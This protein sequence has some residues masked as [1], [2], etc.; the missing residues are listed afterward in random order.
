[1]PSAVSWKDFQ[2]RTGFQRYIHLLRMGCLAFFAVTLGSIPLN[3]AIT[4]YQVPHPKAI[5]VLGGDADRESFTAHFV[6]HHPDLPIWFSSG[7]SEVDVLDLFEQ[8]IEA[9]V[10]QPLYF[11][12]QAVDTVTNFTTLVNE[13][14]RQKIR[15][16]FLITSD[17][18]MNR[19]KIIASIVLG[20]RKIV[21]TPVSVPSV[22]AAEPQPKI[23]RDFFRSLFW[24]YTGW[25][26]ENI[27]QNIHQST[28][29][30]SQ[31]GN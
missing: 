7:L 8:E 19:A 20:S 6:K 23:W 5:L 18:H 27:H 21:M 22:K 1:M 15:H 28:S 9:P 16:L 10:S 31:L 14:E 26:G 4:H 25:S 11:D 13:F 24:L 30:L 17:Y 29:N 12:R 3:I 2:Q